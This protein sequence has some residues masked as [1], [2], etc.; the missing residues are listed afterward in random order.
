VGRNAYQEI[1]FNEHTMNER[2]RAG[3]APLRIMRVH[4]L[5]VGALMPLT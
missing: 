4:P 3:H 2:R 5:W 1:M